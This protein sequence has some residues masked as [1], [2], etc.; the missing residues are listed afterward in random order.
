MKLSQDQ[1]KRNGFSEKLC[2][3]HGFPPLP[4][5][6]TIPKVSFLLKIPQE[7]MLPFLCAYLERELKRAEADA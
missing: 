6:H 1:R 7:G 2:K 4:I 3:T 5:P